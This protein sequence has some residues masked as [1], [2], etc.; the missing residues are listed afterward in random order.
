M[1]VKSNTMM[2]PPCPSFDGCPAIAPDPV[3]NISLANQTKLKKH[4][5]GWMILIG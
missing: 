1:A 4:M 2:T 5:G 3:R